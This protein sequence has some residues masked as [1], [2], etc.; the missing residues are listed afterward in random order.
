M[1]C[2]E[3]DKNETIDNGAL[4]QTC[5]DTAPILTLDAHE[6]HESYEPDCVRCQSEARQSALDAGIPASVIDGKTKLTEHFTQEYI[7]FKANRP[8]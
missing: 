2:L 1:L 6:Y 7:N 8:E 5:L 3:C 4:C